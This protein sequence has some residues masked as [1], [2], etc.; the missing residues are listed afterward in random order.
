MIKIMK[1]LTSAAFALSV[2]IAGT[3]S[4]ATLEQV[5]DFGYNPSNLE[6]YLYV[7]E[8]KAENAPILV[9]VHYC[10]GSGPT[11]FS[12]SDF[13]MLADTYGYVVIY[14]SATR[15]SKCFDVSSPQA[16]TRDGGSDPVGIMSMVDYVVA[17]Y[18]SKWR[19]LFM[20]PGSRPGQ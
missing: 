17:N 1:T 4:A 16:L 6:M 13:A 8:S 12:D 18:A 2:F 19:R 5:T 9:A 11:F 3:S 10:T 7:P 15:S 20:L 14:P